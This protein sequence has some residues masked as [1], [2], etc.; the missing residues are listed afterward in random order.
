MTRIADLSADLTQAE[1]DRIALL[2]ADVDLVWRTSV[3]ELAAF[4]RDV[5]EAIM[6]PDLTVTVAQLAARSLLTEQSIH[7]L[8]R[9]YWE[10]A[11]TVRDTMPAVSKWFYGLSVALAEYLAATRRMDEAV[12]MAL[13]GG[14]IGRLVLPEDYDETQRDMVRDQDGDDAA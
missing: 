12:D 5:V 3:S 1:R 6:L 11:A 8:V 2:F 4:C 10:T 7:R 13:T 14:G 9:G